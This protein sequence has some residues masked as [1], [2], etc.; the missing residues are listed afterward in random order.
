MDFATVAAPALIVLI[1]VVIGLALV[2][3][4]AHRDTV[5]VISRM[6]ESLQHMDR[7]AIAAGEAALA[8]REAAT[9]AKL[10]AEA[11][12]TMTKEVVQFIHR[13]PGAPAE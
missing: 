5:N 4:S 7:T 12:M 13:P 8:A 1:L 9:A 2:I 11:C 6:D 10:A 3:R